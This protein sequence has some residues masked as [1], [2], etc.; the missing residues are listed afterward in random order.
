MKGWIAPVFVIHSHP[1]EHQLLGQ[2]ISKRD[3]KCLKLPCFAGFDP[4]ISKDRIDH[5]Q[6]AINRLI[7]LVGF[8]RKMSLYPSSGGF[9]AI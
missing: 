6:L 9:N 7:A 3:T 4:T 1:I 2:R 5:A 8:A